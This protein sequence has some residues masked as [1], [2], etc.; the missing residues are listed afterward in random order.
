MGVPK[1]FK[2]LLDNY[3]KNGFVFNKD[4]LLKEK[5][6]MDVHTDAMN[7]VTNM[8]Y[9]LID[10]NCLIH[11]VCF[12]VIAENQSDESI[13]ND[14]LE[15]KMITA[16]LEYLDKIISYVNPLKGVYV[17][18]D[19]VAP[20]A[21]IKQQRSRRFKSVADKI[22][23]DNLKKKH[24]KPTHTSWN[25]NAI[26]PGT[27]FM[28]KLNN[29]IIL[30]AEAKVKSS[31]NIDI[32]YSSCFT[33]AEGEHKLLQFI[34]NNQKAHKDFSYVVYG[35]DA[36]LIFLAL[37]TNSDKV[38][39]LR[40]ANEINKK[41]SHE[42]LNYVSIKIMRQCIVST[43]EKALYCENNDMNYG[44]T[45]NTI[46]LAGFKLN[47]TNVVNDFIFMCYFLGN[48][49]L[50]HIPS[51]DIAH[52]GIEILIEMYVK[53]VHKIIMDTNQL[54]YMVD[55]NNNSINMNFLRQFITNIGVK[56]HTILKDNY[57][58]KKYRPKC[59]S[60]DPYDIENHKIDNL[61]FKITDPIK[62]GSDDFANYRE[63]YYKHYWGVETDEIEEFSTLLVSQYMMG[64]LWV[65]K[66]YFDTCPAWGWY[67]PFDHPPFISDIMKYMGNLN[68]IKF[69]IGKPIKPFM[70]LLAVFPPQ[71]SFLIPTSL[72]KLMLNPM[73]QLAYMYPTEF[74]QDFIGK[75]RYWMGIPNLPPLDMTLLTH[76]FN[77]Y[78]DELSK[79]EQMRNMYKDVYMFSK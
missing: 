17:A 53:V 31:E 32:I 42:V 20:V 44:D 15:N 6:L 25:N 72:R 63:R 12:K 16:V 47:Q 40:E 78:K 62:L 30:W 41:E 38:Y 71:S 79:E 5:K 19:G 8:D 75:N 2:Y 48:D 39:L 18:I 67:Y 23:M 76:S 21:K 74:T 70:Q 57:N 43:I 3:K 13:D 45:T 55:T 28:V 37:S 77:K 65:T 46:D 11:P 58:A 66:Y 24:N 64:I 34:R 60:N 49:F 29:L 35:L 61:L 68:D 9:F 50:P 54:E 69:D 52:N 51:L 27:E 4:K 14:K 59:D 22:M 10:A 56:E 36:D 1:F 7:D 26:T 73:S 33:P